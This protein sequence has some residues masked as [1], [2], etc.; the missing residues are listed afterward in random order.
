MVV[1]DIGSEMLS[2]GEK[3]VYLNP[4]RKAGVF[5]LQAVH[6]QATNAWGQIFYSPFL[7]GTSDE[8]AKVKSYVDS[9]P[10]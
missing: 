3:K 7:L 2:N 5:I 9:T 6:A 8:P 4:L 10:F 1:L